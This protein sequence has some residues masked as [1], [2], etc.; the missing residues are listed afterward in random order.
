MTGRPAARESG[1]RGREPAVTTLGPGRESGPDGG[2]PGGVH[3]GPG[4]AGLPRLRPWDRLSFR[5]AAFFALLTFLAVGAVG[6]LTYARAQREIQDMV[7]TQLLN[8]SRVAALQVDAA[9]VDAL[10]RGGPDG[11]AA[12]QRIREVLAAIQNETLLTTPVTL[13]GDHDLERRTARVLV[14]SSEPPAPGSIQPIP[15]ELAEAVA[16]TLTDGVARNS[17]LYGYQG[18]RWISALAGVPS[19]R[20][21]PRVLLQLEYEVDVYL[22][23]LRA[24][25]TTLLLATAVGAL[26]TL[27]L[28]LVV[29]HRLTRPIAALTAG[30]TEVARGDL[31]RPLPVAARDEVGRLTRAFNGMLEG[32]RQRDFIRSAFGR[33]VSPEVAQA[34]LE[35]PEGLRFGGAKRVITVLMSDLRGYTRFAEHG[36]PQEVMEILNGYLA[37]MA[38]VIIAHGGTINEFMGDGIIA[39]YGAP[40]PHVDHAERAA[41]TAIAMQRALVEVNREHG[42]RGLPAFEMGIGLHTGEAVVGNIGSERRAKYAVVGSAVNVA[43]R[44]ESATVGGQVLLTAATLAALGG[45]ARVGPPLAV[46][47]KGLS[48]PLT[49]HEL[50]AIDGRY[51]AAVPE[52][53]AERLVQ[54]DLPLA[55]WVLEGKIVRPESLAGVAVHLGRREL[56]ARLA[57][58]LEPL[59]NVKLEL[60]YP[61]SGGASEPIYA[62]VL[63]A[64]AAA[65][66][67]RM[68]ITALGARDEAAIARLVDAGPPSP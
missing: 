28:G 42:A 36:D 10:L 44:V 53:A 17:R 58:P 30:V 6:A 67:A 55:C 31:S 43:S 35:S 65:G 60:R 32:L 8:I 37:R 57:Q 66:L 14:T 54:V 12:T 45:L 15:E 27:G 4:L 13:R 62:K 38:D 5:L 41:G 2:A 50:Q 22:D 39:V 24:F 26:A 48:E 20:E 29:V 23:R 63:E 11:L 19:G 1:A 61:G 56:R 64:D 68:R 25:E 34:I 49:L 40:V 3:R 51:A 7:G 18:K 9:Q 21:R 59:T 46:S 33:Y 52:T 47:V 16:W